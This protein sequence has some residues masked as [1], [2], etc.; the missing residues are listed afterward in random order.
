MISNNGFQLYENRN[1]IKFKETLMCLT[2]KMVQHWV[3]AHFRFDFLQSSVLKGEGERERVRR[4]FLIFSWGMLDVIRRAL[5]FF[6]SLFYGGVFRFGMFR[7]LIYYDQVR[8]S[9][10]HAGPLGTF[11]RRRGCHKLKKDN[12]S[13]EPI[14]SSHPLP[15]N[16]PWRK[17]PQR[18]FTANTW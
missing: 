1:W 13:L 6:L 16:V 17:L 2:W 15:S 7:I 4:K 5:H 10:T 8:P 18:R 9:T 14:R 12:H 3:R 11:L